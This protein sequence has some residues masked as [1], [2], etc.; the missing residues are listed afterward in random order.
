MIEDAAAFGALYERE[1]RMVL[2]VVMRR[3]LDAEVALD[4]TAETF[5][6][7]FCA[8]RSF[9]GTTE[10]E[11]RAWVLTI[12]HRQVARYARRRHV[13]RRALQ[14][15]GA[16]VPTVH[17]D[18]L[19]AIED[20]AE[21]AELRDT[22]RAELDRLGSDQREAVRLRVIEERPYP[23]VARELRISEQTARARVCRGLRSLGTA[24][25]PMLAGRRP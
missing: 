1:S 19:R 7:A 12:A 21:L 23:E 6:Q 8:R 5:A 2:V 22:V 10:A 20:A 4:I 16:S 24:L 25:D 15:L 18:D 14:R 13:E 11:L 3:T 9:R 17:E